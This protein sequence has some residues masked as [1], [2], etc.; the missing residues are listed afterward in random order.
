MIS[1]NVV[2]VSR[3]RATLYV[4][5]RLSQAEKLGEVRAARAACLMKGVTPPEL[6]EVI[7]GTKP[8]RQSESDIANCDLTG[9]GAQDTAIA[10]FALTA[11]KAAGAGNIIKA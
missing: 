3:L 6:G 1:R 7:A 5:D 4:C 10:T 2:Q 11:A 9:T 8:G